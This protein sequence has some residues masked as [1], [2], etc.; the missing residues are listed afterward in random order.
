MIAAYILV[1]LMITS[2][3]VTIVHIVNDHYNN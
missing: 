1:A 2:V 3:I